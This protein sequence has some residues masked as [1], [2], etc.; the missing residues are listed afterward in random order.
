MNADRTS[1]K[2]A[3]PELPCETAGC[4]GTAIHGGRC[5]ACRQGQPPVGL[6]RP[7]TQQGQG[8]LLADANRP[9]APLV[10]CDRRELA[11]LQRIL[12]PRQAVGVA[13]ALGILR[14]ALDLPE[15]SHADAQLDEARFWLADLRHVVAS[16]PRGPVPPRTR[17]TDDPPT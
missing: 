9:R 13:V 15:P 14:D 8:D 11:V 10:S 6:V 3:I 7:S 16:W 2:E 4:G 5:I 17:R 12:L 1:D